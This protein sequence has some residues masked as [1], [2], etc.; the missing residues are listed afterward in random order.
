MS[1]E[2]MREEFQDA[3][4][5]EMVA[6]CGEGFRSSARLFFVEKEPDG[7]Y[8]NPIA[9]AGWWAWQASRAAIEVELPK[10]VDKEWANTHAER[11]AMREAIGWCKKRIESLG[12]KVK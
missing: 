10:I 5:E 12:L 8:S 1:T 4:T 2:K 7:S 3:F 11:S 9:H 6:R